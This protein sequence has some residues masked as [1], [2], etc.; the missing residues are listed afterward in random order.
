MSKPNLGNLVMYQ[1][2]VSKQTNKNLHFSV[3]LDKGAPRTFVRA[4]STCRMLLMVVTPPR[5]SAG[6]PTL[7]TVAMFR[8]QAVCHFQR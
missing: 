2:L 1:D 8:Y 6:V 7:A 3:S 5:G 4:T